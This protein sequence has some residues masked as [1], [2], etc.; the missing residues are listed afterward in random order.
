VYQS[1]TGRP[2]WALVP[3]KP[4]QRL[5]TTNNN[6][7]NMRSE[8]SYSFAIFGDSVPG[9][10]DNPRV[11]TSAISAFCEFLDRY[12]LYIVFIIFDGI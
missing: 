1:H 7:N 2:D 6:N 8:A 11:L 12:W 4:A 9:E 3:A 5:N 10:V